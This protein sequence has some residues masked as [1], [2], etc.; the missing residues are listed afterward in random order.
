MNYE[1]LSQGKVEDYNKNEVQLK[2]K[3]GVSKRHQCQPRAVAET[4]K[5]LMKEFFEDLCEQNVLRK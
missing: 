1:K 5:K 2:F 3:E 4:H